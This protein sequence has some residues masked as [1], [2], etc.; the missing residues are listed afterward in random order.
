MSDIH[1]LPA[2]PQTFALQNSRDM[3]KKLCWEID[4]LRSEQGYP[5]WH[6]VAY[7]AFNC[8]I[9]AWSLVDWLWDEL[10]GTQKSTFHNDDTRFRRYCMNSTSA[11]EIC[12]SLANSSKHRKRRPSQFNISVKAKTITEVK[13]LRVGDPVGQPLV[14]WKWEAIVSH[15][16]V[17][18]KAIDVFDRAY[19]DWLKLI[20]RYSRP[21]LQSD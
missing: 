6:E 3:C 11:L 9:T 10:D 19:F 12:E 14:T 2:E 13:Y 7:R 4:G 18:H 1:E 5:G 21:V 17:E 20:D 8:A 16:G 15:H